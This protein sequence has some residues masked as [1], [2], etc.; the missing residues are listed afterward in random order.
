M[1]EDARTNE[2]MIYRYPLGKKIPVDMNFDTTEFLEDLGYEIF[3][4]R[5]VA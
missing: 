4:L 1:M 5:C 2:A 3:K